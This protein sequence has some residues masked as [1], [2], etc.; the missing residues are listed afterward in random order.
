MPAAVIVAPILIN[1]A[2]VEPQQAMQ[3]CIRLTLDQVKKTLTGPDATYYFGTTLS[4]NNDFQDQGYRLLGSRIKNGR[5]GFSNLVLKAD[6]TT[7]SPA[8]IFEF[9]SNSGKE[10][11]SLEDYV[12]FWLDRGQLCHVRREDLG[13]ID[14]S[15]ARTYKKKI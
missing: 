13:R 12:M 5:N 1:A 7:T 9:D 6:M 15:N 8:H 3:W 11:D 14:S 4:L 2:S 10:G